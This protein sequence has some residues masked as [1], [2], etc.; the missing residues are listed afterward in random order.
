VAFAAFVASTSS[1]ERA[2]LVSAVWGVLV[3]ARALWPGLTADRR[4][5]GVAAAGAAELIAWW[6]LMNSRHVTMIEA[7]TLPLAA[8]A[9]LAGWLALRSRPQ[10]TSWVAY[11][12]ALA[13]ALLPSLAMVL[14]ESGEPWRRLLL[15]VAALAIVVAGAVRR[16]QAPFVLGGLALA[17][18]ALHEIVLLWQRLPVWIPLSVGGFL[19]LGLA[20]TYERRR[21]DVVRLRAAISRMG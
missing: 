19:L 17:V 20:I 14:T 6:L 18:I 16:R 1:L 11:G 21:R 13:A 5:A 12:P 4:R 7:Y 9:L 2:A 3:G 15:G 8:V 10:L